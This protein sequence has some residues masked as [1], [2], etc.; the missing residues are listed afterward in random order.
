[1]SYNAVGEQGTPIM[2]IIEATDL[3]DDQIAV[4]TTK[5]WR[6][7]FGEEMIDDGALETV[8]RAEYD[9]MLSGAKGESKTATGNLEVSSELPSFATGKGYLGE[10]P[11]DFD[12]EHVTS[13]DGSVSRKITAHYLGS[14]GMEMTDDVVEDTITADVAARDLA[15][16]K[17]GQYFPRAN[18]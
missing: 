18:L 7:Q 12:F 13:P 11:A 9:A 16:A 1:M 2:V 14:E 5:E 4:R 17:A 3:G 15:R 8:T 6:G 10:T